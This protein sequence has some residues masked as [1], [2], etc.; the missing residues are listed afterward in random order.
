MRAPR[1]IAALAVFAALHAPLSA[2]A[3]PEEKPAAPQETK[4]FP[5][6]RTQILSV[7]K[8]VYTVNGRVRIQKGVEI[9]VLREVV[10]KAIGETPAVIEVEGSLTVHGVKGREVIFEN[11]TI[12]PC[13]N[14]TQITMDMTIFRGTSG[15]IKTARD[16]PCAG[17]LQIE[18]FDILDGAAMDVS[19]AS[20]S[21][22]LSSVCSD[23]PVKIRA[24]K[25]PGKEKELV[26]VFIR[27]CPQ[28][29]RVPC[30]PH[31]GRIGLVGGLEV[32]G[33]DDVTIQLSRIGGALCSVRN[34]GQRL[35]FD[36]IKINSTKVEF[37]H[38]K[39][40][41]YQRVQCAKC[42][43]YSKEWHATAPVEEGQK[44]TFVVDRCWFGGI[45]D[46]KEVME[47]VVRDA[48]DEPANNG[49]HVV[50]PKVGKRP[51]ELAGEWER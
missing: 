24:K 8:T 20:G 49:V 9:S 51:L 37:S 17:P 10:I 33:G 1:A 28:D 18:L 30:T 16:V 44:D 6:D 4:P 12:E 39:A 13:A 35:I 41:Q 29:H 21:V 2:G 38:E 50:L 31:G 26:R 19:M 15:G 3:A 27:G 34:W 42:D 47:K 22:V 32:D 11:V 23:T 14:F 40:G 5:V 46:P 25:S 36:G 45:L 48:D 7:E 43:V